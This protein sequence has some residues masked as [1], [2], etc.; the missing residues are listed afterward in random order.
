MPINLNPLALMFALVLALLSLLYTHVRSR[1][2][3]RPT[4]VVPRPPERPRRDERR[5]S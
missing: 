5:R 3:P 4:L 1:E 2:S